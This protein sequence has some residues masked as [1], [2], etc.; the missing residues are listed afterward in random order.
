MSEEIILSNRTS[1]QSEIEV[2]QGDVLHSAM[3][4]F[5]LSSDTMLIFLKLY[6]VI[7]KKIVHSIEF[8]SKQLINYRENSK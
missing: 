6:V 5:H 4:D 3:D 7:V 1:H 2:S 8:T